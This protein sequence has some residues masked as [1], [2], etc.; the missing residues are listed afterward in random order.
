MT[1]FMIACVLLGMSI[2]LLLAF[3]LTATRMVEFH[4]YQAA[5]ARV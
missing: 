1:R 2:G 4:A 5:E 3:G